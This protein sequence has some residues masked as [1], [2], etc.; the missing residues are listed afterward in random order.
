MFSLRRREPLRVLELVRGTL[1]AVGRTQDG[2]DRRDSGERPVP[3]QQGLASS[4]ESRAG[5]FFLREA[6]QR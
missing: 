1:R 3:S 2:M 4:A 6:V 5:F